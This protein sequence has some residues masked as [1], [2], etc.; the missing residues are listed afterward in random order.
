MGSSSKSSGVVV[1]ILKRIYPMFQ[2]LKTKKGIGVLLLITLCLW[3]YFCLPSPL[4]KNKTSTVLEDNNGNLLSA[5]IADDG[6]WRF[7]ISKNIPS[8]FIVSIIQFED[9]G[10]FSHYGFSPAAF[11]RAIIQNI[12]AKKIVSGGSTLSMQVIRLSRKGKRRTFFEKILEIILATRLELSYSK[13]DILALYASNAPFGGNVVG[14]DAASWRYFGK[15]ASTLSWAEAAVLAILPNA[16]SLIY[17]GKNQELLRAKRNR[18][19]D[20]LFKVKII[21]K[22]ICELS[23]QEPLPGK[24]HLLPQI[25]PHLLQLAVQEG[26][27]GQRIRSTIDGHLQKQ[28]NDIIENNHKIL[29]AN[30][31]NNACAML[32]SS[33]FEFIE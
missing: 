15:D 31:I 20:Q 2:F 26:F 5:R 21:D 14:I 19:I 28:V 10:F 18:L 3:F 13:A 7:P 30:E 33:V 23:K 32:S 22:E 1:K 11:A 4:F 9:R 12:K 17:P 24:P 8:K 6:Q 27:N 16:P 29:K 25:A